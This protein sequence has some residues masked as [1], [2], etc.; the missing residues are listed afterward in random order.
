M[1]GRERFQRTMHYQN[2][3][4]APMIEVGFWAETQER[5][6][7][8]GMPRG[9]ARENPLTFNGCAFFGLDEQRC[10]G[11]DLG[12]IPGFPSEIVSEDQRTV[13]ARNSEG[14]TLRSMKCGSSMPQY[15]S[16]PLTGREDFELMKQ[17]YD[18]SRPER[19]PKDWGDLVVWAETRACPLWGPGIGSVGFYSMLRRWMGTEKAC[20][21]FYDDPFLAEEMVEFIAEFTIR[22]M[23]RALADVAL[24]YF[25][26]WEDFAFKNGPLVSPGIFRRFLLPRYRRVN[27]ALRCRG[28]DVIFLDSDGDVRVL[29][30]LLL[31]AGVNGTYP[32]EA[33]AGMDPVFLRREYKR[34]LLLWGGVDKRALAKGKPA[35][36]GELRAK[37]PSLLAD[38]GYIPQLDHLAPPDI[39]YDNWMFYLELKR[40]LLEGG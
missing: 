27:E 19:Y 11:L 7:G 6:L 29:L 18:P 9:A 22:A 5:W 17:R 36:E 32:I 24:D 10:L 39:P 20:T 1:N 3:D 15:I 25:M 37:L 28:T 2:V 4:R 13:T 14:V 31:E 21:V 12:M 40:R 33:A 38:G 16:W 35:I 34:D 26:W 30:P 23:E 8:E